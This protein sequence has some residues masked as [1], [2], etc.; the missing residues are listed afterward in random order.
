MTGTT[1]RDEKISYL[2]RHNNDRTLFALHTW[3]LGFA[4]FGNLTREDRKPENQ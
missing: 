2:I 4:H 3:D 1:T